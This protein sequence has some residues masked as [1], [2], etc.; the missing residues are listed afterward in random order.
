MAVALG[1]RPDHGGHM[2]SRPVPAGSIVV[3]IDGS[4]GADQA[5]D[6]ATDQA[7]LEH[8]PLVLVCSARLAAGGDAMWLGQPG[9]DI[10]AILEDL[11]VAS[12][13]ML[14]HARHRAE[15]RA[16]GLVVHES[17]TRA[18][19]R[20]ALVDLGER[21]ATVV[22]G[23]RGRGPIASALLGS[24]SV[25]LAKHA[26]CPVVVVRHDPDSASHTGVVVDVDDTEQ[27][28]VAVEYA[29]RA[30]SFRGWPLTALRVV[31][32]PM[33]L[34]ADDHVV[35]VDDPGLTTERRL[36][37]EATAGMREKFPDVQDRLVLVRGRREQ[38]LVRASRHADLL[39]VGTTP[40]GV[41]DQ[42]VHG[43]V[44]TVV[45]HA[46]CDV[47]VLPRP[48]PDTVASAT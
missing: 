37:S 12:H 2:T 39:V 48:T 47:A 28:R 27:G 30:A 42:L 18:D 43:S 35:D 5:L 38:Q 44:A 19:P 40:Y 9:V 45:E 36:L 16:P 3:G 33:H 11:R 7:A 24:V 20:T 23:S 4:T 15:Q 32:D 29:Y 14:A 41:L 22:V 17:L 25:H 8:R 31:W 46:A 6:W 21:A 1:A 26:T 13:Q 10:G 34:G